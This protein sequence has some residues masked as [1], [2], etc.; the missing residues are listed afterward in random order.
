MA[1][2]HLQRTEPR[3]GRALW[4]RRGLR[5]LGYRSVRSLLGLLALALVLSAFTAGYLRHRAEQEVRAQQAPPDVGLPPTELSAFR[6]AAT[7]PPGVADMP[8]VLAYHDIAPQPTDGYGVS[9]EDFARQMAML[10]AAGY[11]T[12]TGDEFVA[13]LRGR[14]SPPRSVLIT[15]DDGPQGLWTHADRILARYGFHAVAFVITAQVDDLAGPYYL[16]WPEIRR[17]KASGRWTIGSHTRDSHRKIAVS[18][19]GPVRSELVN[20]RWTATGQETLQDFQPRVEADLQGSIRDLTSHGLPRPRLFAYPFSESSLPAHD[21]VALRYVL[22]RITGLFDAAFTS[23]SSMPEP[24]GARTRAR[25]PLIS[26]RLSVGRSTSASDLFAAMQRMRTLPVTLAAPLAPDAVWLA[27][28]G[29]T[30]PVRTDGDRLMIEGSRKYVEARYAAQATG[31]WTGYRV[32][33]TIRGLD[34]PQAVSATLSV[35]VGGSEPVLV[36]VGTRQVQVSGPTATVTRLDSS[37]SHTVT[38]DVFDDR[39]V[40]TVDGVTR[41]DRPSVASALIRGGIGVAVFR[42]GTATPFPVFDSIRV[43]SLA[44]R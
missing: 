1:L 18:P 43:T 27:P 9:R 12:L 44:R 5:Q 8:I 41:Y 20:R 14:P 28:G 4:N 21:P 40:V 19:T 33:A 32:S 17:M 24:V 13:I 30:V 15:F 16:S 34:R 6:A 35:R 11:R 25:E 7:T 37:D 42:A 36:R 29:G 31:D 39:T 2:G 38:I 10:H 26:Y 3:R 23:D 22:D